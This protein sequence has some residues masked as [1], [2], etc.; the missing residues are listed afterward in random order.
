MLLSIPTIENAIYNNM[1]SYS[2]TEI[3]AYIREQFEEDDLLQDVWITGEISNFKEAA[4]GHWYFSI[5][6]KKAQLRG[7]MFKSAVLRQSLTPRDGDELLIHG[8]ISV[9]EQRGEY[10]LYADTMQPLGSVGDLYRQFEELK[11][12]LLAA[13][14]FDAER[15]KPLPP[16]PQKIGIV[17]SPTAAAFQDMLNVLQRRYPLVE[18]ILSPTL[19]QGIEAPKQIV[20][21]IQRLNQ[22]TD[23][24]LMI[25]GRGGGSIED[26]WCFNDERVAY[27]IAESEIPVISG[28]GHEIDFTIADF[29][30]DLRAPTPS[31]AAELATPDINEL[32][33]DL[34]QAGSQM[35]GFISSILGSF[36]VNLTSAERDLTRSSPERFIND[37][38]QRIDELAGRLSGIQGRHFKQWQERLA[39]RNAALNAAS[40]QAILKRGYAIVTRS[41]TGETIRSEGD[42]PVGSGVTIRLADD[43]LQARIEDKTTHE[44][45]KRTLF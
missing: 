22:Y 41:D 28:V 16:A 12:Q 37:S 9:Y 6:D 3:T 43:T 18:V 38:R 15:K 39:G 2:V 13:G 20:R 29:A 4:S 8:R 23:V 25:V 10:Q 42:A 31:A 7:V 35:T 44:Q 45:Y 11:A 19:V 27:A 36:Q 34:E 5:K 17:T 14:L 33:R 30:A 1:N 40:P 32:V 26:L 21:A 24:D